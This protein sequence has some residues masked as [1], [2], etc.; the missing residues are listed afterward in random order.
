MDRV[1]PQLAKQADPLNPAV[2]RMIDITFKAATRAGKWVAVCGGSASDLR[3]TAI[4]AGLIVKELS[5]T[6]PTI[7][8]IKAS[9]RNA[10]MSDLR[11]MAEKAKHLKKA[12]EVR[13]L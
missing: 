12:D 6:V 1:H 5:V 13:A 8:T 11:S 7:S 10:S 2:L 3:G 9:L 4:L